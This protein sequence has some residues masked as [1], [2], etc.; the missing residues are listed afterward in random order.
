MDGKRAKTYATRLGLP[1][2]KPAG[3]IKP[4][5]RHISTTVST[6]EPASQGGAGFA[7]I[8]K[9]AAPVITVCIV[10]SFGRSF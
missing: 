6:K 4:R 10:I 5:H 3:W 9:E 2:A 1:A 7:R 8:E